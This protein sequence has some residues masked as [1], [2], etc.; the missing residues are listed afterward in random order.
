MLG[1]LAAVDIIAARVPGH[2]TSG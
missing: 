1:V 2:P